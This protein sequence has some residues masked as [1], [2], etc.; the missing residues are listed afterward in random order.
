M[1]NRSM[2]SKDT[3]VEFTKKLRIKHAYR[4]RA[5]IDAYKKEIDDLERSIPTFYLEK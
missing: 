4:I 1:E 5:M 2:K 3:I